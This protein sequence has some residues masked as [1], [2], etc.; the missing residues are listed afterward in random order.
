MNGLSTGINVGYAQVLRPGEQSDY[1][2]LAADMQK[3]ADLLKRQKEARGRQEEEEVS[4]QVTGILSKLPTKVYDKH[5]P[6]F[7]EQK[8]LLVEQG[9]KIIQSGGNYNDLADFN[10][11]A[12][13]I[14]TEADASANYQNQIDSL[15]YKKGSEI[16]SRG[17]N[18]YLNQAVSGFDE[19]GNIIT[20]IDTS[21]FV[22]KPDYESMYSGD[23]SYQEMVEPKTTTGDFITQQSSIP[24]VHFQSQEIYKTRSQQQ[25]DAANE[26]KK[27]S[28]IGTPD[29]DR[30]KVDFIEGLQAGEPEYKRYENLVTID[31]KTNLPNYDEAALEYFKSKSPYKPEVSVVKKRQPIYEKTNR[32]GGYGQ[33]N[34]YF[35]TSIERTEMSNPIYQT[36]GVSSQ[37]GTTGKQTRFQY[38]DIELPPD[39]TN[40][41]LPSDFM[42]RGEGGQNQIKIKYDPATDKY[43]GL[44][45]DNDI[46]SKVKQF[47]KKGVVF[48]PKTQSRELDVEKPVFTKS[49]RLDLNVPYYIDSY[50]NTI[51]TGINKGIKSTTDDIQIFESDY[52]PINKSFDV[53][54]GGKKAHGVF[55][56]IHDSKGNLITVPLDDASYKELENAVNKNIPDKK[57]HWESV[58][59]N[60]SK[61][62]KTAGDQKSE[63]VN[64]PGSIQNNERKS[65]ADKNLQGF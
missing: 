58:V 51:D 13:R 28:L 50:G 10:L 20:S 22:L 32:S 33:D 60:Q 31:P 26:Y 52:D 48:N 59:W 12:N 30:V 6:Y 42:V 35:N 15:P 21:R 43:Y 25:I 24:G 64:K 1:F 44:K 47:Q 8:R 36:G 62:K 4:K 55:A 34:P 11:N 17:T 19:N 39:M 29:F 9:K 63:P 54:P 41:D 57:Y 61:G 37:A 65:R 16:Y 53:R 40:D 45:E 38:V 14:L 18:Q 5:I 27:R 46:T 56:T 7:D 2:K 3:T 49:S 23:K